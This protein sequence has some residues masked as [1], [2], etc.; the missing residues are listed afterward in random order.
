[1]KRISIVSMP[2]DHFTI[3]SNV[4]EDKNLSKILKESGLP[5]IPPLLLR[6]HLETEWRRLAT[7]G[8]AP[9]KC[10]K[11]LQVGLSQL[12]N[13]LH[14]YAPEAV[15]FPDKPGP[16]NKARYAFVAPLYQI[17]AR[18]LPSLARWPMPAQPAFRQTIIRFEDEEK[19]CSKR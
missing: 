6:L 5:G 13:A 7:M 1:V 8:L 15:P 17:V 18:F 3:P 9:R 11:E 12:F 2:V 19:N 14:T 16:N 4:I 10:Q